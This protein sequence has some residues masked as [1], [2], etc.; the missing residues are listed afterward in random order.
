MPYTT[1]YKRAKQLQPEKRKQE[2]QQIPDTLL[3]KKHLLKQPEKTSN[4]FFSPQELTVTIG[5]LSL[6]AILT[7]G[8]YLSKRKNK[9]SK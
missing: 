1:L 7:A 4:P 5:G 6:L 8:H 2:E 3:Q 9:T